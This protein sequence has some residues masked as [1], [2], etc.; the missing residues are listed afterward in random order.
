M[1]LFGR[2]KSVINIADYIEDG[3]ISRTNIADDIVLNKFSRQ[4]LLTLISN[5]KIKS[6][7]FSNVNLKKEKKEN[8]N[9]DY[10]E[11]LSCMA[12]SEKFDEE[13][14]MYLFEV[15]EYYFSRKTFLKKICYF[16]IGVIV[17]GFIICGFIVIKGC[18][19]G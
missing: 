18:W 16:G 14:L 7:F 2:S 10:L 5:D 9:K 1:I 6:I 15:A 19:H 3:K 17:V 4:E 13:Y 12:V 8:W 11:R